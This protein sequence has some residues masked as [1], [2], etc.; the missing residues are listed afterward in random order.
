LL[1]TQPMREPAECMVNRVRAAEHA[2]PDPARA[3]VRKASMADAIVR[4][5]ARRA[6]CA[7]DR[8]TRIAFSAPFYRGW[9][10]DPLWAMGHGSCIMFLSQPF[11]TRPSSTCRVIR[12]PAGPNGNR[13]LSDQD[14]TPTDKRVVGS[15]PTTS[16]R[17]SFSHVSNS[18]SKAGNE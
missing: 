6:A 15:L 2:S 9:H 17:G 14:F 12:Q 8:A 13:S 7:E 3:H 10:A 16:Q 1:G 11:S 18:L 4:S 5:G